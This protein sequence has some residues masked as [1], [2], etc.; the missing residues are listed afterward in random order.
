MANAQLVGAGGTQNNPTLFDNAGTA[1]S[2]NSA[3]MAALADAA[4]NIGL[5]TATM[6]NGVH[7]ADLEGGQPITSG[8]GEILAYGKKLSGLEKLWYDVTHPGQT[9]GRIF[10]GPSSGARFE[11]RSAEPSVLRWMTAG[12]TPS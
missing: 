1:L 2:G 6:A 8:N 5:S 10:N 9:L 12:V 3:S 4:Q 7:L 11:S